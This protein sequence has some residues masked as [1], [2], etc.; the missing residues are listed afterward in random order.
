MRKIAFVFILIIA[1]SFVVESFARRT[2]N[3]NWRELETEHF[4]II[5]PEKSAQVAAQVVKIGEQAYSEVRDLFGY[6]P[7]GRTPIVLNSMRDV[8]N[9]YAQSVS[10]KLEFYITTPIDRSFGP[11]DAT[12]LESLFYHEYAHL[13]QGMRDEGW[14]KIVTS[15]FGEVHG[16][17]FVAPR[18]WVEGVAIYSESTFLPGGRGNNSYHRMK[19]AANLLSDTPWSMGQIGVFPRFSFP[20]DRVYIPGYYLIQELEQHFAEPALLDHLSREQTACPFFGL[21]Y[22]WE[23]VTQMHPD[24]IWEYVKEKKTR[25]FQSMY[26]QPRLPMPDAV[27]LTAAT[28]AQYHQPVWLTDNQIMAYR[29]SMSEV[30]G[31]VLFDVPKGDE[32]IIYQPD[33]PRGRYGYDRNKSVLLVSRLLPDV[34][35]GDAYISDLFCVS[36]KGEEKQVT[37]QAHAWSPTVN[38]KGEI[39]CVVK[40]QAETRLGKVDPLTGEV[41]RIPGPKGAEYLTPCWSPDGKQLAAVVRINGKQDVCLVDIESGALMPI[42]GWDEHGDFD[43]AWSPDGKYILFVSDR[44]GT[45]QIYA[46]EFAAK[47]L[48]R[49]TD[50]YLGA[51]D[52][53]VSE[54]GKKIAFAEYWPGNHQ[55]I[56]VAPF[57]PGAWKSVL[58]SE[59][60]PQPQASKLFDLPSAQ[61]YGYSVWKHLLPS[62]WVPM[63]G[64]DQ[65]G[66]TFGISSGQQDPLENHM[67]IGQILVQPNSGRVYGDMSYTN[68]ELPFLLTVDIFRSPQY[69]WA[70][71][72]LEEDTSLYWAVAQGVRSAVQLPIILR[73]AQDTYVALN[74]STV[75]EA[76]QIVDADIR[77]FPGQTYTGVHSGVSLNYR[78]QRPKDMFPRGGFSMTSQVTA[79]MPDKV[80]NGRQVAASGK[81][82]LP[83]PVEHQTF[84]LG[85]SALAQAGIFPKSNTN[86]APQGYAGGQFNSGYNLTFSAGYRF[87]LWYIDAGPGLWPIYFHDIWGE[88]FCDLGAGWDGFIE[89][90]GWLDRAVYSTGLDLHLDLEL[91]WYVPSCLN[92]GLIFKPEAKE[93]LLTLDLDIDF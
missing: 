34:L 93:I 22:I 15:V 40:Q 76:Y 4:I 1:Q 41:I 80:Y 17:N 91:F 61:G 73:Q 14:Y 19:L 27:Y 31:L 82:H 44:E 75:Y 11:G 39:I 25:A 26:G 45:H 51:F 56:A 2:P 46:Y 70:Q 7:F 23:Q 37:K 87:P 16:V 85:A 6:A 59:P 36:L 12:W 62:F 58:M 72:G 78:F 38:D 83:S 8:A 54:D 90:E 5:Y 67:W 48:Y 88:L 42:T 92:T 43:P 50:A 89:T 68:A 81:V 65:D 35:Y 60:Q 20:V 10:R 77:A 52:P 33:L 71:P 55:Q 28:D 79:A 21:G 86:A 66:W 47:K 30:S 74:W 64:V 24:T 3:Q 69:R 18:W 84:T 57:A 53:A 13:C 63:V 32:R 29:E 9:G 49:I